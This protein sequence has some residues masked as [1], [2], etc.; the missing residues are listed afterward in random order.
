MIINYRESVNIS[1][2]FKICSPRRLA[3]YS[4]DTLTKFNE[5]FCPLLLSPPQKMRQYVY[6]KV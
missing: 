5:I 6:V 1:V 4:K 3:S 2:D